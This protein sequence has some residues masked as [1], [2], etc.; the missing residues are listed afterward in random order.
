MDHG[1]TALSVPL[2]RYLDVTASRKAEQSLRRKGRHLTG[3]TLH[4]E[5]V[6]SLPV[7][8]TGH[9]EDLLKVLQD[10]GALPRVLFLQCNNRSLRFFP[11]TVPLPNQGGHC[12]TMVVCIPPVGESIVVEMLPTAGD[13]SIVAPEGGRDI[14]TA[15]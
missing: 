9:E 3:V 1:I 6:M 8:S 10:R 15:A 11:L 4:A 14:T 5:D 13:A 12:D 2:T 7:T